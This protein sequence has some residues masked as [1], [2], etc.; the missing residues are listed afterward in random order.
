MRTFALWI[1]WQSQYGS[2]GLIGG[3]PLHMADKWMAFDYAGPTLLLS[4]G[5]RVIDNLSLKHAHV[6]GRAEC[7]WS[8]PFPRFRPPYLITDD[9]QVKSA[10]HG[11]VGFQIDDYCRQL[12]R[13]RREVNLSV[14]SSNW[15][16]LVTVQRTGFFRR[17]ISSHLLAFSSEDDVQLIDGP[18]FSPFYPEIQVGNLSFLPNST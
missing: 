14:T 15:F 11:S 1:N 18:V 16:G 6:E 2:E 10:F 4:L 5:S 13:I 3:H 17:R 12:L 8:T 9:L 7:L